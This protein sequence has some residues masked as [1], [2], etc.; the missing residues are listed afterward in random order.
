MAV[1]PAGARALIQMDFEID[2]RSALPSVNVPTLILYRTGDRAVVPWVELS[3]TQSRLTL[4]ITEW[5]IF[6]SRFRLLTRSSWNS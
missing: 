1:S 6:P 3:Y 2:V 4:R 5:S